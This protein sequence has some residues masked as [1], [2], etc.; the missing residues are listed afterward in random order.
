MSSTI[1]KTVLYGLHSNQATKITPM[2]YYKEL[3]LFI[4]GSLWSDL[5]RFCWNLAGG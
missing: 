2:I 4:Q 5:D 1:D 3:N